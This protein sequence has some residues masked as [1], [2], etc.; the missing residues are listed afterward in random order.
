MI[1]I[2]L[3]LLLV[4]CRRVVLLPLGLCLLLSVGCNTGPPP[5]KR[6]KLEGK[7]T[8]NG[9]PV[10]KGSIQFMAIDPSGTNV[11]AKIEKGQYSVP[12]EQGPTKGKYQV[13]FFAPSATK[14]RFENPDFPGQWIEE[15]TNAL[16]ARYHQASSITADY[17]PDKPQ[18]YNYQLTSP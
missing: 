14:T 15:E 4:R 5:P 11:R 1:L 2:M 6:G 3:L 16:P 9:Q 7:V 13:R 12:E 8:L 10:A 17:D 18:S